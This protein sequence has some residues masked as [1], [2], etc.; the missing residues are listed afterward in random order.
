[1]QIKMKKARRKIK[2]NRGDK[3]EISLIKFKMKEQNKTRR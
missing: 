2:I 1:M 3:E